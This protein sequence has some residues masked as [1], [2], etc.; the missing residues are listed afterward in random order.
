MEKNFVVVVSGKLVRSI[1]TGEGWYNTLD[2]VRENRWINES[3]FTG[4]EKQKMSAEVLTEKAL[5]MVIPL[6]LMNNF[7]NETP[8]IRF[9]L[10]THLVGELQKFQKLWVQA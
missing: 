6:N 4:S 5:L 8:I 3:V 10:L 9:K 2:I 7:L 1:D